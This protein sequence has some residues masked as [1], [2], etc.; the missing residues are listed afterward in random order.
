M[1]ACSLYPSNDEFLK[2]VEEELRFQIPRLKA[3]PSIALWCGDNEVIGA[4][5]WY[6]ESK[7]NKVKYTVNYDRLN[8]MIEQVITQQDD[9]RRFWPSSPAMASWILVTHGTMIAKATCTFG[10]YG[11]RVNHLARI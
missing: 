7:H 4:I 3:H 6:D 10:M 9:S 5:G 8:R 2:D 1:F 11:I